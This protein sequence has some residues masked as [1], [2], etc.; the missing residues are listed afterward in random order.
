MLQAA[1]TGPRTPK[2][3]RLEGHQSLDLRTAERFSARLPPPFQKLLCVVLVHLG[4]NKTVAK[5]GNHLNFQVVLRCSFVVSIP[6]V[7]ARK[8]LTSLVAWLCQA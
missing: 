4:H 3:D 8:S 6:V 5:W 1:S 7:Y 2:A